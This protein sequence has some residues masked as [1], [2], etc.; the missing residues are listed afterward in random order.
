MSFARSFRLGILSLGALLFL[1]PYIFMLTDGSKVAAG[2]FLVFPV[3]DPA[4]LGA[5]G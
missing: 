2:Y 4:Q 3:A 1:A 5:M